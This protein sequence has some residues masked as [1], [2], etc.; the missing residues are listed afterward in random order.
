MFEQLAQAKEVIKRLDGHSLGPYDVIDFTVLSPRC[1]REVHKSMDESIS[2]I[3]GPDWYLEVATEEDVNVT[4]EFE[5]DD[6]TP[7]PVMG[8]S[9]IPTQE[10]PAGCSSQHQDATGEVHQ[11]VKKLSL[12]DQAN[13]GSPGSSSMRL[14]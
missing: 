3:W 4:Y 7:G 6:G 1:L 5:T 13:Q 12:S 8:I 2:K 14:A 10:E 11:S 9:K